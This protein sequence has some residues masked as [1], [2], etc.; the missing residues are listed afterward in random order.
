MS[1]PE[2]DD[3]PEDIAEEVV[4]EVR[5]FFVRRTQLP[6]VYELYDSAERALAGEPGAPIAGVPTLR[7]SMALREAVPGVALPFEFSQR[8]GRWV[9]L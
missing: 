8:F 3:A 6:D 1:G 5:M 9:V 2:E 7:A 4:P